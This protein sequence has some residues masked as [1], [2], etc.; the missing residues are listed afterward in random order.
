M[1]VESDP[2]FLLGVLGGM[3]PLATVDFLAKLV[4]ATPAAD[5]ADHVPLIPTVRGVGAVLRPPR[6]GDASG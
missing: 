5:D 3:G 4:A 2:G 6:S 1:K